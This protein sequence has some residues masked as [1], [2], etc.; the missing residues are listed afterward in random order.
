MPEGHRLGR[1][2]MREAGHDVAGVNGRLVDEHGLEVA[3][4]LVEVVDRVAHPE[5]EIER[6]L[7][8][9]RARGVQAA[10]LRPDDLGQPGLDIHMNVLQRAREREGAALDF[11][12][13]LV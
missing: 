1:L 3:H 6:H 8:V 10:G 4:L 2:Q 11:A 7:I 9:A 13:H 12:A 5:A